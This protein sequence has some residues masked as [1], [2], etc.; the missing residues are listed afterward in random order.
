MKTQQKS[1]DIWIHISK[2]NRMFG[3]IGILFLLASVFFDNIWC[4]TLGLIF[5]IFELLWGT[6]KL[7]G[8]YKNRKLEDDE[9]IW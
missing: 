5:I 3:I 8:Y 1:K 6:R 4:F 2:F 9:K 7:T